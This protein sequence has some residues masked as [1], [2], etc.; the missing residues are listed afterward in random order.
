MTMKNPASPK[1]KKDTLEGKAKDGEPL[2]NKENLFIPLNK[3]SIGLYRNNYD[4][5][6]WN[7]KK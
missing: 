1:I 6:K 7:K 5:I 2:G 3:N 4:K